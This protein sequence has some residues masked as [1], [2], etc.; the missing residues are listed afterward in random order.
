MVDRPP[1]PP[2]FRPIVERPPPPPGF[3]P[4]VE[5][6]QSGVPGT[7][8]S[9]TQWYKRTY[10]RD[11]TVDL[12]D[13]GRPGEYDADYLR[14]LRTAN[15]PEGAAAAQQ[16]PS[17]ERAPRESDVLAAAGQGAARSVADTLGA[18]FDLT[19]TAINLVLGVVDKGAQLFGGGR[20][21]VPYRLPVQAADTIANTASEFGDQYLGTETMDPSQMTFPERVAYQGSRFAAGAAQQGAILKGIGAARAPSDMP[22]ALDPLIKPYEGAAGFGTIARDAVAGAGAGTGL[23]AYDQ[24]VGEENRGPIGSVL[25][26]LAGGLG[27]SAG[28]DLVTGGVPAV[29]RQARRSMN[30]PNIPYDAAGRPTSRGTVE[31]AARYMQREAGGAGPS[32][33]AARTLDETQTMADAFRMPVPPIGQ[34]T[35]NIGLAGVEQYLASKEGRSIFDRNREVGRWA[36]DEV[37]RIAPDA[38]PEAFIAAAGQAKTARVAGAQDRLRMAEMQA[39]DAARP[40]Q[41]AA[42]ELLFFRQRRGDAAQTLDRTVVDETL[43]PMQEKSGRMFAAADPGRSAEVSADPMVSAASAVRDSLGDFNAP[44]RI[45]PEGLLARIEGVAASRVGPLPP[46]SGATNPTTIGDIIAVY[47]ELSRTADA[48]RR[49]GNFKLVDSIRALRSSFDEAIDTAAANGDPAALR[50]QDARA[51]YRETVGKFFGKGAASQEPGKFRKDYNFDRTGTRQTTP[52]SDTAGRFLRPADPERMRS[53]QDIIGQAPD[54]ATGQRAV[55]EYLMADMAASGVIDEASRLVKPDA[56]RR[57]RDKWG[58]SLDAAPA[59]RTEV[60]QMIAQ[61]QAGQTVRG[62]LSEEVNQARM[63]LD[64]A[65]RNDG[66]F[67][68]VLGRTPQRAVEGLIG[69]PDPVAAAKELKDAIGN[70]PG[71]RES[72]QRAFADWLYRKITNVGAEGDKPISYAKLVGVVDNPDTLRLMAEVF[73]DPEAMNA[74]QRVRK[75]FDLRAILSASRPAGSPTASNLEGIQR[76]AE[77]G[78]RS[79]F[80]GFRGGNM[81]RNLKVAFA[82]WLK[83]RDQEVQELIARAAVDPRVAKQLLSRELMDDPQAWASKMGRLMRWEEFYRQANDDW[84][85]AGEDPNMGLP[86][87]P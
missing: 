55:R 17:L 8:E 18:P 80:G 61:A 74:L 12:N 2:G 31:D 27:G 69:S 49:A 22:R 47:P 38:D 28:Y 1:P 70:T 37:K 87:K 72:L 63:G 84:W 83:V 58:A 64:A 21:S 9:D 54:P 23:A 14:R 77:A 33:E 6:K 78:L 5:R 75:A 52:P 11:A 62:Q 15:D 45:I 48:A 26:M 57:W 16:P 59:I 73:D 56:L 13:T 20:A 35:Q 79:V 36:G 86:V 24:A 34:A 66:A 3:R 85:G 29:L 68:A 81:T 32:R 67:A 71:A 76:L 46:K 40:D 44:N 51:N 60:D 7:F 10:G 39:A 65:T 30:D 4:I 19:N 41:Q 43:R 42:D 53:L 25:A 82:P 50:A